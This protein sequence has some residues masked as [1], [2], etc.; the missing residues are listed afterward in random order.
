[1]ALAAVVAL[2]ASTKSSSK[3]AY[4]REANAVTGF[5]PKPSRLVKIATVTA[6][7]RDRPNESS[8]PEIEVHLMK[9]PPVLQIMAAAKTSR[10][11][12]SKEAECLAN[13][14]LLRL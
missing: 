9:R 2:V 5:K 14:R 3:A 1:M 7:N 8:S 12:E 13:A 11:G 10:S 4:S 6:A